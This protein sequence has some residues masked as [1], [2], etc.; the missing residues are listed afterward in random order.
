MITIAIAVLLLAVAVGLAVVAVVAGGNSVVVDVFDLTVETT[1]L[2]VFLAGAVA[3]LALVAAI[4]L[5]S[6]GLKRLRARHREIRDLRRKVAR[7]ERDEPAATD[8]TAHATQESEW[9]DRAPEPARH[10]A[11]QA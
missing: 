4:A 7:L 1:P 6:I 9:S 11:G 8:E 3:G 2:V 10:A 5:F